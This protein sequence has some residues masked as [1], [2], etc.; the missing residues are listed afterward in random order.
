MNYKN[1]YN[2]TIDINLVKYMYSP[3]CAFAKNRHNKS[4]YQSFYVKELGFDSLN[5]F[6][7]TPTL[8]MC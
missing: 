6:L 7:R 3:L 4:E 1:L 8:Y 5:S 2:A